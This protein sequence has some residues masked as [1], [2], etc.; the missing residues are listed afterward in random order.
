M[1]EEQNV[2]PFGNGD[3][4]IYILDAVVAML[5]RSVATP[6]IFAILKIITVRNTRGIVAQ[7]GKYERTT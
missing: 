1:E 5:H 2:N 4:C 6:A 3:N 7:K